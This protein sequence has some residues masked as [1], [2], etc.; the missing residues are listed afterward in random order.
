[1]TPGV[2]IRPA[3]LAAVRELRHRVLR[4]HQRPE[5][6][7]YGADETPDALHLG[8]FEGE[9]LVAIASITREPPPGTADP[10][11]WRVRGMAT[12]P[13]ARNRGIGSLLLERCLEHARDRGG[14]LVWCNGRVAARA[15]YE[16]HGFVVARGPFDV[17]VIGPH[18][19]LHRA[20]R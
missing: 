2:E 9:R 4:P 12:L 14:A 6:L 7:V 10:S 20:L 16:R 11:A 15:F 3:D 18:L 1:M 8:A 19:E 13:E 17:P 5:E